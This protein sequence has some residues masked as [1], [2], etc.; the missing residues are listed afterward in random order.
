MAAT[1]LCTLAQAKLWLGLTTNQ[2]DALL[3]LLISSA[4]RAIIGYCNRSFAPAQRSEVRDGTGTQ[5]LML[6]NWPVLAIASLTVGNCLVPASNPAPFANGYTYDPADPEPP[7]T[8]QRIA[9]LPGFQRGRN[10]VTIVYTA[11]YEV[12]GEAASIPG[13]TAYEVTPLAPWGPWQSDQGVTYANG[14]PLVPVPSSPSAGQ[15][16]VAAGVYTFAAADAG[17]AVLISYGYTPAEVNEAA[18]QTVGEWMR[19]K[20]RIGIQSKTLA[21]QE[22]IV[23]SKAD[24]SAQVKMML[25]NYMRVATP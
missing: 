3:A 1:D 11:G 12:Q 9:Y 10:N 17:K 25:N 16:S 24:L 6:R 21:S 23:Y 14:T 13:S 2:S 5:T 4:S 8:M 19:Y 15:Y 20:D 18:I 22:T 7:G